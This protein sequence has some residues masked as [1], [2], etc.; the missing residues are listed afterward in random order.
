LRTTLAA[1]I[2]CSIGERLGKDGQ[3]TTTR[4]R[5][6]VYCEGGRRLI[7]SPQSSMV[8]V[9]VM[10]QESKSIADYLRASQNSLD[11]QVLI[12]AKI[13]EVTL[14]DGYES[15]IN[16]AKFTKPDSGTLG[17]SQLTPGAASAPP[18]PVPSCRGEIRLEELLRRRWSPAPPQ[19]CR[20]PA[21]RTSV[22]R[23][24]AVRPAP[25]RRWRPDLPRPDR[26]S[27]LPFRARISP[28]S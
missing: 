9:H 10:P 14:N 16:W 6:E 18:L 25:G 13:L 17:I 23:R 27:A 21:L 8:V 28:S 19:R 5:D 26:Y 11:K 3:S 15:G 2:G 1:L 24:L 20:F 4:D 7:I 12:K 22:P